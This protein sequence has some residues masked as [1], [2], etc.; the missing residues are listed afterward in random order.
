MVDLTVLESLCLR[1][2]VC[3]TEAELDEFRRVQL[4]YLNE[5]EMRQLDFRIDWRR[6][7]LRKKAD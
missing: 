4:A 2:D 5:A 1:A 7:E 3:E 6:L